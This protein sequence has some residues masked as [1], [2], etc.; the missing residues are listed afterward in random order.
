M[1]DLITFEMIMINVFVFSLFNLAFG[2][3]VS[4]NS[5]PLL[6]SIVLS[7][8]ATKLSEK[9]ILFKFLPL[10][11]LAYL[12]INPNTSIFYVFCVS[13]ICIFYIFKIYDQTSVRLY[14][15]Y[16]KVCYFMIIVFIYSNMIEHPDL[17]ENLVLGYN[18]LVFII[19]S[20]LFLRTK[21][22]YENNLN[23][24]RIRKNNF[25]YIITLFLG[26]VITSSHTI[27]SRIN[28][29]FNSLFIPLHNKFIYYLDKLVSYLFKDIK[30]AQDII[31]KNAESLKS[32]PSNE[33]E[34][35]AKLKEVI[36]NSVYI[37]AINR[38]L[39]TLFTIVFVAILAFVIYKIYNKAKQSKTEKSK[40]IVIHENLEVTKKIKKSIFGE[41]YPK[42][43]K[44]RIRYWYR[45]YLRKLQYK[46]DDLFSKT[47]LDV[48]KEAFLKIKNTNTLEKTN[49][50]QTL[51]Q[52][53][54]KA[55]YS[56]TFSTDDLATI[57]NSYK[58]I[59]FK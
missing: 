26:Y 32:P 53:Y 10:L 5:T 20:I 51:R 18:Y 55:R 4:E 13:T 36:D 39:S 37:K 43:T 52:A 14:S 56:D 54:L 11:S 35:A 19:S 22:H 57:E 29:A 17:E 28:D 6:I 15:Q 9:S 48:N 33:G 8:L 23:M 45:K 21:R 2:F 46:E 50:L 27:M 49:N 34:K 7:I 1:L 38:I 30:S 16:I 40:D 59:N 31:V 3:N 47:S 44:D 12:F 42:E 24:D 25:I 58:N 41:R